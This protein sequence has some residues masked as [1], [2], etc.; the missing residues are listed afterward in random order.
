MFS[1][2]KRL[3]GLFEVGQRGFSIGS[4]PKGDRMSVEHTLVPVIRKEQGR[5]FRHSKNLS[6]PW[7]LIVVGEATIGGRSA[8]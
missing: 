5:A 4:R 8:P 7:L 2:L 3:H 6:R 1:F